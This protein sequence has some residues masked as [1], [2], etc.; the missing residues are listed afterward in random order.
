M[1][2]KVLVIDDDSSI[3]EAISLIL[4]DAGYAV[5]TS[6]KGEETYTKVSDFEP[7]VI[8]LDVLMSGSDGRI[9]CKRLK[10]TDETKH[11]PIIMISAHPS[12]KDSVMECGA[13]SFLPKPFEVKALLSMIKKYS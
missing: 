13:D 5:A 4:E 9:I 10:A 6:I 8:I 2:K 12:A 11:I 7:D 1:G 3:L